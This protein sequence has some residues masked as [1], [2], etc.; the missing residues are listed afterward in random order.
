MNR[1]NFMRMVAVA[2]ALAAGLLGGCGGNDSS[3]Q[4]KAKKPPL[5]NAEPASKGTVAQQIDATGEVVAT[6]AVTIQATVEGPIAFCPW[7]EGDRVSEP[8]QKL[9]EIDRSLYRQEMQAAEA[10][11]AVAKA[12]LADLKAGAR[13]EEIAQAKE[14]V[15]ELEECTTFARSDL[16]R[17]QKL[18]DSGAVPGETVEKAHVTFI[19]CQTQLVSAKEK[20]SMLQA[21]PTETA[22]AVQEALVQEAAAKL[23]VARAKLAE[24]VI[25]APFAGIVT[26]VHVRPG[27]LATVRAPL[28]EM[29]ETS[30]LVVRFAVPESQ[31]SAVR[32]GVDASVRLDAYPGRTFQAKIAR[33]YPQ[34][35]SA[36]RTRTVEGSV[37]DPPELVPGMFARVSVAVHLVEDAVIVPDSAI[38]TLPSGDKIAFV[39]VDGKAALRRVT[40]GIEQDRRVQV[41]DG[42]QPGELVVVA[43]NE[44]LKDGMEVRTGKGHPEAP[45]TKPTGR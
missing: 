44:D 43:G 23:A 31:A 5:V 13:P 36:T 17:I 35:D 18:V 30:S 45:E 9:I 4:G 29:M 11:L 32:Q 3:E 7:R 34:L 14:A 42:I 1:A 6:N 24:C 39:I 12:K 25:L 41:T 28:L 22:I 33:V 26:K 8:G 27:D 16:E 20:L 19:K 21:G 38:L 2:V 15:K 10:A 40:I 37:T